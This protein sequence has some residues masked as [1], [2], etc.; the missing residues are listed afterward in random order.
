LC[1]AAAQPTATIA[2][3]ATRLALAMRPGGA[4]YMSF[5]L[6]SGERVVEGRVFVDHTAE[7]LHHIL[8]PVPVTIDET[9]ISAD[10]RSNRQ[11]EGWLNA[12]A[13][14]EQLGPTNIGELH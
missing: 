8:A 14:V 4:W 12:I 5:K 6:G 13:A 1:V 7:T 10:I 3:V 2:G 9:W 11:N